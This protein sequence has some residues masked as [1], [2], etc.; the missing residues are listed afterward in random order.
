MNVL[1]LNG[2]PHEFGC[3][4][5]ALEQ[6]AGALQSHGIDTEI[7]WI[8]AKPVAGCTCCLSCKKTG[9][10]I[11]NDNVNVFAQKAADADG[12]VV[13]SPVYYA[14]ANGA[15]IAFLD[16]LF[17]SGGMRHAALKPAAAVVSCRRAGSTASLDILHKYFFINNMPIV[18]SQYWNMVHGNTPDEVRQ[19]LEGLQIM[20]TLGH[21]MAWMLRNIAAGKAAGVTTP[22]RETPVKT[23][24]I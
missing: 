21:N 10:C 15:A 1:L 19:D 7:F 6:V 3:T 12:F 5:T 22:E 9:T 17:Y 4:Y 13:G 23:N 2:S 11:I 16:R 8:G 18:A 24:F 14:S 20:R